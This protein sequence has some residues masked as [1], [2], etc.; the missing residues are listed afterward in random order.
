[1]NISAVK[2]SVIRGAHRGALIARK[3]SPEILTTVGIVGGVVAAVMGAKATLKVEPILEDHKFGIEN[4]KMVQQESALNTEEHAKNMAYVYT[5]TSMNLAK[6]YAP[7]IS[8]GA[9]SIVSI[10]A[11]H[12]IMRKRNASLVAAYA[13]LEKGFNE[14]R[15]RVEDKVGDAVEYD[16]RHDVKTETRTDEDGKKIEVRVPG[17][18]SIYARFFD[19]T[20]SLWKHEP[21]YN[22]AFLHSQQTYANDLLRAR[23]HVLLNDIY[24]ALGF[25]RTS[26]GAVVGWVMNHDGDNFIDFG[27]FD[28]ENYAKRQ[29]IN[30]QE[31]AIL[32]D[33][34]VDGVIYDK[35]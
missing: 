33:F 12:G 28:G 5:K 11:G 13:V 18:P 1:M 19:E 24:D 8:L 6:L 3:Y 22:R 2:T 34:N 15:K 27:L 32:L 7:A 25:D 26:A 23:G 16:L 31:A 10:V 29:F 4:A 35:I 9:A 21:S 30:G 17:S 14:Y 20:N